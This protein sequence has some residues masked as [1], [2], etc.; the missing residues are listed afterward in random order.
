[1]KRFI[2]TNILV[3][4]S[5]TV[6]RVKNGVAMR[7]VAKAVRNPD[8]LVSVQSFNE[9]SSVML[10]KFKRTVAEIRESLE[11]YSRIESVPVE[12]SFTVRALQI[13]EQYQLQFY[14]SLLLAAA[15]ANGCTEFLSEDLND[16][17]IYCGMKAVNP[18]KTAQ[19]GGK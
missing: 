14:D 9:F 11:I 18:F 15:E 6:S 1:M 5:D 3:Y 13:Q 17:Q 12:K 7:I 4:A 16:G 2:D 8:Y 19:E 10:G